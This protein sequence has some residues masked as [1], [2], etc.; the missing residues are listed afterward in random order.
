MIP[1]S[2]LKII[3]SDDLYKKPKVTLTGVISGHYESPNKI[4]YYLFQIK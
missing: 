3:S 4:M 2:P 1:L